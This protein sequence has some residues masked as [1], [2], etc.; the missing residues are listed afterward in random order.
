MINP[1][2]LR[3]ITRASPHDLTLGDASLHVHRD[4]F[5][6]LEQMLPADEMRE[7]YAIALRSLSVK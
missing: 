3:A 1:R 4:D 2:H 5:T 7:L 6:N